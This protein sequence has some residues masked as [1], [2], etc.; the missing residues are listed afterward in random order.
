MPPF[1]V[2][3]VRE[4]NQAPFRECPVLTHIGSPD[5]MENRTFTI[6]LYLKTSKPRREAIVNNYRN[7]IFLAKEYK[8]LI[9]SGQAINEADL[10]RQIGVSRVTVNH[11]ITLLSLAPE[12]IQA[13]EDMGDPMPKR[14]VSERKLRAITKMPT[15]R[16]IAIIKALA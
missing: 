13:L 15:K 9:E 16:Q 5:C 1:Q 3:F 12:V 7:P 2:R 6:T 11:F 10:A 4:R 14:F 8:Q